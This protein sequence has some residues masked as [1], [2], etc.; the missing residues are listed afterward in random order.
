MT[1]VSLA[2]FG[3]AS[4][5]VA[6]GPIPVEPF[7]AALLLGLGLGIAL[8]HRLAGSLG[9]SSELGADALLAACIGALLGGRALDVLANPP[10]AALAVLSFRRGGLSGYGAL[11]GAAIGAGWALTRR[12]EPLLPWFDVGLPAALLVAGVTRLGCAIAGCDFGKAAGARAPAFVQRLG[13]HPTP[14]YEALG[15]LAIVAVCLIVRTRQRRHGVVCEVAALGY[16]LVRLLVEP[17]RGDVDRGVLGPLSV[18]AWCA[19]A[20]LLALVVLWARRW[21]RAFA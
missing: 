19:L 9:L 5:G 13:A 4:T 16:A 12:R 17:L 2:W 15:M 6:L 1:L 3:A 10:E 21:W 18:T 7:G 14:L 8:A 20:T 11:L